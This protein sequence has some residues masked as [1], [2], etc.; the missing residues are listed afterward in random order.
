M[1]RNRTMARPPGR[2]T[3]RMLDTAGCRHRFGIEYVNNFRLSDHEKWLPARL[4]DLVSELLFVRD[5][6]VAK[7]N[8]EDK[9]KLLMSKMERKWWDVVVT[10][11]NATADQIEEANRIREEARSIANHYSESQ[12]IDLVQKVLQKKGKPVVR[13]IF[14]SRL[15]SFEK[16]KKGG[17]S[18][19][20]FAGLIHKAIRD[21]GEN[22]LF[23]RHMTS[24]TDPS[25]VRKEV[26]RQI[27][28]YGSVWIAEKFFKRKMD[29]IIID[30]VRLKSPAIPT[31]NKCKKCKGVGKKEKEVSGNKVLVDCESCS[32][33]GIGAVSVKRCDTTMEIWARLYHQYKG[34]MD[35]AHYR[36]QAEDLIGELYARGNTFSYR[37]EMPVDRAMID[38][39]LSDTFEQIREIES[40][41]KRGVF[42]RNSSQ[43]GTGHTSCPYR[44]ICSGAIAK[45]QS[46]V[47][48]KLNEE[49][50]P[51]I[52]TW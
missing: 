21:D 27:D 49:D 48:Y 26:E 35:S 39:W 38:Q 44:T 25:E 3:Q 2:F 51:G 11:R 52:D 10:N 14:E 41:K 17:L 13:F 1:D 23:I 45:R 42:P 37:I 9:T 7:G 43:C 36:Q 12:R 18:K 50:Y 34:R 28:I 22:K 47:F 20:S 31:L 33:D 16:K 24:T 29:K 8:D 15:P 5:W 19:Y 4:K 32:G 40:A 46:E 30:I 6:S